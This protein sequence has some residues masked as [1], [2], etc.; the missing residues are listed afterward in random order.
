[1]SILID[2]SPISSSALMLSEF[3]MSEFGYSKLDAENISNTQYQPFIKKFREDTYCLFE[4]PYVDKVYRDSFYNYFASKLNHTLKNTIKISF[5]CYPITKE[6]FR[7]ENSSEIELLQSNFMGFL[8]IR[9][10]PPKVI[11]R[12]IISPAVLTEEISVCTSKYSTTVN[13]VKLKVEGFPHSSQDTETLTCAETTIWSC[14]DY[15][16][17]KYSEYSPVLPSN[18]INTL[19]KTSFER[20]LPSKGLNVRQISAALKEFG[21]GPKIYSRIEYGDQFSELFSIYVE[22]GIPIIAILFKS[23]GEGHALMAIGRKPLNYSNVLIPV[24]HGSI[25]IFDTSKIKRDFVF[26]DD[27]Y[28]PYQIATFDSPCAHYPGSWHQ[29]KITNFITPLYSKIY[30]EAFRARQF[31][32]DLLSLDS[33]WKLPDGTSVYIRF[34]LASSRSYKNWFASK[35]T[36]PYNIKGLFLGS[37]MP[38]FIWVA[39][40][41]IDQSFKGGHANGLIILDA[42]SANTYGAK[43]LIFAIYNGLCITFNSETGEFSAVQ[44]EPNIFDLYNENLKPRNDGK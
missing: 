25:S 42:T 29:Y 31:V 19:S 22:S 1:M 39:E 7:S 12:N 30:L 18:I 20:Q 38:K 43:P 41:G 26:I 36:M 14:M 33:D 8:V 2:I 5:F 44:I 21:F 11:G 9:P 24:L 37:E 16:S 28:P 10:T 17:S 23:E 40:L 35:S 4:S 27:N 3:L 15:F 32:Y 13:S 6:I 34:F